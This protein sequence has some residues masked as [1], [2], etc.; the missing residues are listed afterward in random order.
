MSLR[1]HAWRLL[2]PPH[3]QRFVATINA[4]VRPAPLD[5]ELTEVRYTALPFY[6]NRRFCRI[7]D[8]RQELP[9]E[10]FALAGPDETVLL[11]KSNE[12]IHRCNA[13]API[14]LTPGNV[15]QY[16]A[17]FLDHVVGRKGRFLIV[18]SPADVRWS[19]PDDEARRSL[20]ASAIEPLTFMG[21]D[22][23]GRFA[24]R[25]CVIFRD[26]LFRSLI[27][28]ARDGRIELTEETLLAERLPIHVD[29]TPRDYPLNTD[30][31]GQLY[32]S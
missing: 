21:T 22:R 24:L 3:Q 1:D 11:N 17:F 26:A 12:P 25:A 30:S 9:N 2:L 18:E 15:A 19:E 5:P 23:D 8:H 27:R 29:T 14:R 31:Q 20:A 4:V 10:R 32:L 16:A 6:E 28:V 7:I 13:T